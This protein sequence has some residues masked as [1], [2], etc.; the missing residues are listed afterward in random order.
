MPKQPTVDT[1][2]VR[3]VLELLSADEHARW[4]QLARSVGMP[5]DAWVAANI[6]AIVKRLDSAG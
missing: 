2:P 6:R 3:L 4:L 1:Y 5:L